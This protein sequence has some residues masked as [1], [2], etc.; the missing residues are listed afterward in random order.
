MTLD[1]W[2]AVVAQSFLS[3]LKLWKLDEGKVKVLEE[4][5]IS[6]YMFNESLYEINLLK[7]AKTHLPL[8]D[9][10]TR[11][12]TILVVLADVHV[13]RVARQVSKVDRAI[14]VLSWDID[15]AVKL[16]EWRAL[17]KLDESWKVV[18]L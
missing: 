6:K 8:D 5:P 10:L 15:A 13:A 11:A 17:G 9:D 4:R 7:K 12:D 1:L 18:H 2:E 14:S 16:T 3:M